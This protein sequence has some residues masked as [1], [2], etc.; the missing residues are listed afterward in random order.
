MYELCKD[1]F[2]TIPRTIVRDVVAICNTCKTSQPLKQK[3]PFKH[4]TATYRF[5]HIMMDLIGLKSYKTTN[6]GFCCILNVIDVYLKFAK[7]C[8]LK[9]KAV[10]E[11]SNALESPFPTFGP[12]TVLQCD[13]GKKFS[14]SV[15][16]DL[17]ARF[18]VELIRGRVIPPNHKVKLN[19]LI[20]H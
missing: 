5:E 19:V 2:F 12:P 17:C 6:I 8:S 14:N 18:N 13:N 7:V 4:V 11:V 3:N 10:L 20:K 16:N 15:I 1:Y 9:S